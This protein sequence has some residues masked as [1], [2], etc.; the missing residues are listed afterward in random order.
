MVGLLKVKIIHNG[1]KLFIWKAFKRKLN[2]PFECYFYVNFNSKRKWFF[3]SLGVKVVLL[4]YFFII[5]DVG[6][7]NLKKLMCL[8][9]MGRDKEEDVLRILETSVSSYTGAKRFE[10]INKDDGET[11]VRALNG[12]AMDPLVNICFCFWKICSMF[13]WKTEVLNVKITSQENTCERVTVNHSCIQ[14]LHLHKNQYLY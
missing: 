14:L 9:L 2:E 8:K 4:F 3:I 11:F 1:W 10:V 5:F 12:R 13:S 6:F 7:V